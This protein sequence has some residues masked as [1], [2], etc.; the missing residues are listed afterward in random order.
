MCI[1]DRVHA[2]HTCIQ[3]SFHGARSSYMHS[4][5]VSWCRL[6]IHAFSAHFMVQADHTCIQCSFHGAGWSYCCSQCDHLLNY[7]HS[8]LISWCTLIIHAFSAFHGARSSYCCTQC[9]HLLAWNDHLSI[10]LCIVSLRVKNCRTVAGWSYI[11]LFQV[12]HFLF[13]FLD[14]Y[15][16]S[17]IVL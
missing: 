16:V 8:V 2:H 11:I 10:M 9:D 3:C 17:Y 4:V 14:I 12:G 6:I 15:V 13:T 1:R 7:M 5:L